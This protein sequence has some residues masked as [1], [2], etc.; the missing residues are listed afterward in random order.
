[1]LVRQL[2][3]GAGHQVVAFGYDGGFGGLLAVERLQHGGKVF[4][5][6]HLRLIVMRSL[7]RLVSVVL[8][9]GRRYLRDSDG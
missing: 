8:S 3:H 6:N 1:V 7:R 4:H 5:A 9:F 2:D